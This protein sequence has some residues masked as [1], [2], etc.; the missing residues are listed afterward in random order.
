MKEKM[1]SLWIVVNMEH[2]D[3][4]YTNKIKDG[5][6]FNEFVWTCARAFGV[7]IDMRDEPMSAK[8][9]EKIEPND[10][11]F[12]VKKNTKIKLENLKNMSIEE[13]SIKAKKYYEDIIL[14]RR[15]KIKEKN[16]LNKKYN[17]ML[18]MV[19][20]WVVPSDDH[21]DLKNFMIEQIEDSIKS[22]C[23]D[24]YLKDSVIKCQSGKEWLEDSIVNTEKILKRSIKECLKEVKRTNK[25]NEWIRILKKSL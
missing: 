25:R 11:W 21:I 18:R 17:A 20:K 6:S 13:A 4:V 16:N 7:L 3:K 9:H 14:Y 1:L 24:I 12:K 23:S 19:N 2:G 10:Y 8:I 15:M 22:D 5:I